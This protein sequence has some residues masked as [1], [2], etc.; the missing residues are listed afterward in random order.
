MKFS[1]VTLPS[2]R[3]FGIFF[4]FV[5]MV[6][7]VYF[8]WND[9]VLESSIA[10]GVSCIFLLVT[11]VKDDLL[12]PLNKLWMRFGLFLNLIVSPIVLGAIFFLIF[13]PV[14]LAVRL[15]GRDELDL[16]RQDLETYWKFRDSAERNKESFKQQ[17]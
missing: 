12:L 16:K 9:M 17:F 15:F 6:V 4:F 14:G 5:F 8:F 7:A 10:A 13:T 1:E 3:K 2:N 11:I